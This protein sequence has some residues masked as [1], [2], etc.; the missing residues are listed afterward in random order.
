MMASNVPG[1]LHD[2][3]LRVALR[4]RYMGRCIH[5]GEKAE[6]LS[7]FPRGVRSFERPLLATEVPQGR[8]GCLRFCRC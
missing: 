2:E 1:L 6:I 5:V 3:R 7:F 4:L 8:H